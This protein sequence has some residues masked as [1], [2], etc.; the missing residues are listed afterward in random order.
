[1][2]RKEAIFKA[3]IDTGSSVNDV[4]NLD[5]ELEGLNSELKTLTKNGQTN[6][7]EFKDLSKAYEEARTEVK[8]L[9]GDM[10]HLGDDIIVEVSGSISKMEDRLYDL[11][12]AGKQNTREFQ[13]LQQ[14]TANYKKVIIETDRS[15]DALA[16]R[17]KGLNAALSVST[18]AVAGFQAF[19]GVTAL[20][21][22]ENEDLL[23]TITQLQAA[24]GVLNSIE[25]IKQEITNNSIALT[26]IQTTVQNLYNK[27]I[28][29][30]TKATKL[31]RGALLAT[32]IGAI[33]VG[34]GLLIQNF[35]KLKNMLLGV[36]AEQNALNEVNDQAI[37]KVAKELSASDKLQRQ[38]KDET[39][40]RD[41]KVQAVKDL[42]K[43]Y[44][45]LLSNVDAE[46]DSLTK[47]NEALVLNTKLTLL[48]A[49][50]DAIASLRT[51]ELKT[52]IKAQVD[53]QTG[54]N[55]AVSDYAFGIAKVITGN[56]QM[57]ST[58]DLANTKT[59]TAI[60]TSKEQVAVLDELD[61]S[62]QSQIDLIVEQGAVIEDNSNKNADA[63]KKIAEAKQTEK[64][65]INQALLEQAE[66]EDALFKMKMSKQ[67]LEEQA[68]AE[69]YDALFLKAQGNASLEKQ[70]L[71]QQEIEL[72]AI[73][74]THR[75]QDA[76]DK[77]T[78][79]KTANDLR[80]S[81]MR[82]SIDKD[83]EISND[84][85]KRER[86][87]LAENMLLTAEEK[88]LLETEILER[89]KTALDEINKKWNDKE[90][91]DE[92]KK[93]EA[94]EKLKEQFLNAASQGL[95]SL[96]SLN[97]VVS[98]NEIDNAEGNSKLQEKLAEKQFNVNKGLQ[99]AQAGIDG[100]RAVSSYIKDNPLLIGGVPNPGAILGL[101]AQTTMLLSNI[102]K[103]KNSKFTKSGST[104]PPPDTSTGGLGGGTGAG[105][106]SFSI[107]DAL[108]DTT[109][110]NED[111]TTSSSMTQVVVVETDITNAV[112]NVAQI[113]EVAKF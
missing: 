8:K 65:R 77:A 22:D 23:E 51:E 41:Q 31:F 100:Y 112:N 45:N 3:T 48:K 75:D 15:I 113:N 37:D 76:I 88:L 111:G 106:S 49:K 56:V 12:I 90:L 57:L 27:A 103:I 55:V 10:E 104:P 73:R 43:E 44:P 46:K 87:S 85:F 26:R 21:G 67:E 92:K 6:T 25:L 91:E 89:E 102:A 28:G 96:S 68:V 61:G 69:K 58:Q 105:A 32:G 79:T 42:Q 81:L 52:Q 53:A 84:K 29:S 64:D 7:Q 94:K 93:Q 11:A 40:T 36:T 13:E 33:V 50:Q 80:H 59:I 18:G 14:K 71:E 72:N 19:T 82:D 35:D 5:K 24:Q 66:V 54:Q 4:K 2:A 38:L 63:S 70:L 101:A 60:R 78:A 98:K 109:D 86:E 17:G 34:V 97:D 99:L 16:E 30:G 108:S 1:M 95:S 74:K 20:L 9:A 47:V 62:I 39:L 107:G 83:I 110:L